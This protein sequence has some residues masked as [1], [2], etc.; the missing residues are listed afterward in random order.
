MIHKD[1]QYDKKQIS[2]KGKYINLQSVIRKIFGLI[3]HSGHRGPI[4]FLHLPSLKT[5][6]GLREIKCAN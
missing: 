3:K 2:S 1:L 4:F 5:N 6:Q